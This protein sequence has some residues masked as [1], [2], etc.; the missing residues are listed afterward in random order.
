MNKT[1]KTAIKTAFREIKRASFL[2]GLRPTE[3]AQKAIEEAFKALAAAFP[4]ILEE[5]ETPPVENKNQLK[6]NFMLD[7]SQTPDTVTL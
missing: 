5:L 6:F 4:D 2:S 7:N 1:Q 3:M